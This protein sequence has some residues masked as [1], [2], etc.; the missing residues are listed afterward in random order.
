MRITFVQTGGTIDKD[1]PRSQH[2]YA[3]EFGEPATERLLRRWAPS[4]AFDVHTV[5]QKD[6]TDLT[7]DDRERLAAFVRASDGTHFV[8]THGTD[9]LLATAS[10]LAARL[11][12]Q[13]VVLTGAMRPERF[14]DSDAP[15]NFGCAVGALQVVEPGVYVA[16]HGLVARHDRMRRDPVTGG[17]EFV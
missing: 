12:D 4:F 14:A 9:T 5:C 2:G 15:L 1:Y 8:V 16:I 10:F 11:G 6:S 13:R 3:F 17:F 7:D